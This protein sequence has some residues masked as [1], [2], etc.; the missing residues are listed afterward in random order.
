MNPTFLF[1]LLKTV[2]GKGN[3]DWEESC[4]AK[5]SEFL[6]FLTKGHKAE[7]LCLMVSTRCKRELKKLECSINYQGLNN[8]RDL[9][10]AKGELLLKL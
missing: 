8:G 2:L 3:E 1:A 7:I 5:L 6:G 4:L 9:S 10:R